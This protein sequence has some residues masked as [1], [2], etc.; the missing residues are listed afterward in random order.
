MKFKISNEEIFIRDV[1]FSK[2]IDKS[3][4]FKKLNYDKV[5]KIISSQLM[6]PTFY[7]NLK[8]KKILDTI[9]NTLKKYLKFIYEGNYSRNIEILKEV[10]R[11]NKLLNKNNIQHVFLKGSAYLLIELYKNIGERMIGDVDILVSKKDFEKIKEILLNDNYSYS[12]KQKHYGTR[13]LPRIYNRKTKIAMEIHG[14]LFNKKY[15]N[16][17][18][19][20]MVFKSSLTLEPGFKIPNYEVLAR[21]CVLNFQLNDSG[22]IRPS[23][24]LKTLYD[25]LLISKKFSVS[26][27]Q[28]ANSKYY[29]SFFIISSY[30]VKDCYKDK[31]NLIDKLTLSRFLLSKRFYLIFFID[32][33]LTKIFVELPKTPLRLMRFINS[34]DYR[35]HVKKKILRINNYWQ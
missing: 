16:I 29:K 27:K 30:Y 10:D 6:I 1:L 18:P 5:I 31:I 28:I 21:H 3:I 22:L 23:L 24:N 17:L 34:K 15:K 9:P 8:E 19:A 26:L 20:E 35:N 14:E 2:E 13:H 4:N 32:N 33:L 12:V 7:I 11:I 25:L